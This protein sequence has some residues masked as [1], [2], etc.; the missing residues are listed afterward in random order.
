[1]V[2]AVEAQQALERDVPQLAGGDALCRQGHALRHDEPVVTQDG[3]DEVVG[4]HFGS[5]RAHGG[6]AALSRLP[7][8]L[9]CLVGA[10]GVF[11]GDGWQVGVENGVDGH[12]LD[13]LVFAVAQDQSKVVSLQRGVGSWW[14]GCERK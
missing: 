10:L 3:A 6:R 4:Q 7:D 14:C 9:V 11:V 2:G 1:M 8:Q 12:G 13:Y 5:V